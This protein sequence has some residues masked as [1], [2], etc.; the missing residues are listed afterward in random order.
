MRE[1]FFKL[2]FDWDYVYEWTK[3]VDTDNNPREDLEF[4]NRFLK[5]KINYNPVDKKE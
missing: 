2:N 4:K 5:V 3:N 1:L